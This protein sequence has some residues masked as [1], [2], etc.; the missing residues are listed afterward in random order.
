MQSQLTYLL[1]GKPHPLPFH[2]EAKKEGNNYDH[3]GA[4]L[5]KAV[6]RRKT[7][8]EERRLRI[9]A[10]FNGRELT[11]TQV[12]GELGMNRDYVDELLLASPEMEYG[13]AR[14]DHNRPVR[15]WRVACKS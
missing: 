10:Q 2:F 7:K 9:I 8:K 15:L 1:T 5:A 3:L 14:T 13:Y 6:T 12:A 11:A 4:N